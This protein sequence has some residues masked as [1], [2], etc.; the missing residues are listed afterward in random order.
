MLA[1]FNLS[2]SAPGD[3][4]GAFFLAIYTSGVI[5]AIH[6]RRFRFFQLLSNCHRLLS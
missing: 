3:D 4:K 1:W 5:F 6:K 2:L